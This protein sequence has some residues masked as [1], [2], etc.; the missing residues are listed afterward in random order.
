M[1]GLFISL[2]QLTPIFHLFA[3]LVILFCLQGVITRAVTHFITTRNPDNP[4][5]TARHTK[6]A[7]KCI[8]YSVYTAFSSIL[9]WYIHAYV[10]TH[11]SRFIQFFLR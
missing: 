6:W 4:E 2:A 3:Q 10:F 11:F 1:N 5:T 7:G 8:D 9:V